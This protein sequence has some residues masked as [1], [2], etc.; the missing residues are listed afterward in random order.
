MCDF[1]ALYIVM[2]NCVCWFPEDLFEQFIKN[3]IKKN[4]QILDIVILNILAYSKCEW[5]RV[6]D[7]GDDLFIFSLYV[8][9]ML[10]F[11]LA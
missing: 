9:D 8:L 10:C 5:E 3:L 1:L 7:Y 6:C 2:C 4:K 11:N